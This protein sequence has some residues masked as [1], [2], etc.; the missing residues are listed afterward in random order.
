MKLE[1]AMLTTHQLLKRYRAALRDL[2]ETRLPQDKIEARLHAL[3][4]LIDALDPD[5]ASK[6][7]RAMNA[8]ARSLDARRSELRSARSHS[9]SASSQR[10]RRSSFGELCIDWALG[11]VVSSLA[12][13]PAS[14][15]TLTR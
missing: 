12:V 8:F 4:E 7:Q 14:L 13:T 11:E 2:L 5:G 3:R 10:S 9:R 6:R 1:K 15:W